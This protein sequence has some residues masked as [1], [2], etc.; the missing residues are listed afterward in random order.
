MRGNDDS[1][2]GLL[3]GPSCISK[4]RLPIQNVG[5]ILMEAIQIHNTGHVT[6]NLQ[7]FERR[8]VKHNV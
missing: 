1:Y 4:S 6:S 2:S 8:K 5:H 3:F 7:F